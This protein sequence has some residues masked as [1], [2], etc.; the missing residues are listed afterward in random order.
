ML[1]KTTRK[2]PRG[3]RWRRFVSTTGPSSSSSSV[4]VPM[5]YC[6]APRAGWQLGLEADKVAHPG[7]PIFS[8]HRQHGR[9]PLA[10]EPDVRPERFVPV[11]VVPTLQTVRSARD[12]RPEPPSL[13]AHG[14][15]LLDDARPT[16]STLA[17]DAAIEATYYP[18]VADVVRRATGARLV[19]PYDHVRRHAAPA[20]HKPPGHGPPAFLV[21]SD[22]A[23][24]SWPWRVD[25]LLAHPGRWSDV[26]PINVDEA[27][28]RDHLGGGGTKHWAIVNAWRHVGPDETLETTPLALLDDATVRWGSDEVMRYAITMDGLV[29][30]NFVLR[31]SPEHRWF[32]YPSMTRDELLLFKAFESNPGGGHDRRNDP[33]VLFHSAFDLPRSSSSRSGESKQSHRVSLEVRC[34]AVW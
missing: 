25:E 30:F 6:V 4:S 26:G 7:L 15:E 2:V 11:S 28:A 18:H 31:H 20:E 13:D 33:F 9:W 34:I 10:R 16:A 32:Y 1:G 24:R 27:F 3:G 14:F 23:D 5:S 21:H 29:A 12:L 8:F 17:S 22:S 19:R